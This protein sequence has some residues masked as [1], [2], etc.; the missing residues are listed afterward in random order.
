MKIKNIL[1]SIVL[2]T[3]IILLIIFS[4][5]YF[6]FKV[7]LS[8]INTI[9]RVD[10]NVYSLIY[11]GSY[12]FDEFL[13]RGGAKTDSEVASYLT[14]F[15]SG[16]FYKSNV[17]SIDTGCSVFVKDEIFARNFDWVDAPIMITKTYPDDGYSS[18]ATCN[19]SF[20]G[21]GDG[22]NPTD[23]FMSSLLSLASIYVPLDGVNE[24]GLCV[25]DL[26]IETPL[27]INQD[28]G[29]TDLTITTL[30]R[31]LLDKAATVDEALQLIKCYDIHSS[32][33]MMH[34]LA[35]SD[36]SGRSVV[37]EFY[38]NE[39]FV[40]DSN[41]VTNFYIS[42][43]CPLY[44]TGSEQSKK[45]YEILKSKEISLEA[46]KAVTQGN[47]DSDYELTLWSVLFDKAKSSATYYFR[48]NFDKEYTF[49]L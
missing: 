20:L 24:K 45:R 13:S 14:E 1:L 9:E 10:D 12:G 2:I 41:I 18:I 30:I 43:D 8:A 37:V 15:L 28:K 47:M 21:F 16:G 32:A 42:N 49:S 6:K 19:L 22:F 3:L 33:E 26:V 36:R 35:I 39:L 7:Q 11:R 23:S 40:T 31:L 17:E 25:S 5:L 48:E 46:I 4:F 44:L 27:L 29:K 38:E 34:H